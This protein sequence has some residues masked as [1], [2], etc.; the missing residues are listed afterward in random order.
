MK[1]GFHVGLVYLAGLLMIW[2]VPSISTELAFNNFYGCYFGT[3][4]F[5]LPPHVLFKKLER[6]MDSI[7]NDL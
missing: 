4:N 1:A 6:K 7:L 5:C 3:I 2:H